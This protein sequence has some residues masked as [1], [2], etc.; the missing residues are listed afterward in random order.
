MFLKKGLVRNYRVNKKVMRKKIIVITL[1]FLTIGL[2][3][4]TDNKNVALK[5]NEEKV[6]GRWITTIP[7]T[8]IT[9]IMNFFT[10]GSF[11]ESIN[12]TIIWSTYTIIDEKIALQSGVKTHIVEY[13]F[14]NNDNTLILIL[15]NPHAESDIGYAIHL[16]KQLEMKL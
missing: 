15:L 4:C 13:S 6:L 3:G 11:Y 9:V 14:S 7:G 2:S 8:P 10:N 5:S 12:E 1:F 16:N